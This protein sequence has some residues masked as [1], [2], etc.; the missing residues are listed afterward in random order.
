MPMSTALPA[1]PIEDLRTIELTLE[2]AALLQRFFEENPAYFVATSGEPAGPA[3]AIEEITSQIPVDMP[4][5]KQ[6]VVGYVDHDG[7][8]AAMTHIITDLF[9]GSIHHISTFVVATGLHGTGRAQTLYAGLERW[10]TSSGAAWL[11]LGVVR[12]NTRAERFW[13][14]QRFVPVRERPG[15]EM[16]RRIVSVRN[17]VKPLAGGSLEEYF[18]LVPRDR[19]LADSAR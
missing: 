15:I 9:A 16:G 1:S 13:T 12:G 5:T 2:R 10:A 11:R 3:A 18:T 4:F 8:L 14:S 17:M 19:P 6:W 7:S